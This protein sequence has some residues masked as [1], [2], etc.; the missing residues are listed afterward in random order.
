V[1]ARAPI[2]LLCLLT[3]CAT[4]APAPPPPPQPA[5][6]PQPPAWQDTAE[7]ASN[8]GHYL[9]R[10]RTT[11]DPIPWGE[12]FELD[13][14]VLGADGRALDDVSLSIDAAMPEHGHGMKR[15]PVVSAAGHGGFGV[16]GMLFHMPGHWELY[17]DLT[18]GALTERAQVDVE[19]E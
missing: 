18:R 8:A 6:E 15:V 2:Q 11:P 13:V 7:L 16:G 5:P 12:P 14:W 3:A 4:S 9:V 17:F 1:K 10:Y 19:L